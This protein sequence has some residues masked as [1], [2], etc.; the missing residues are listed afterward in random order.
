MRNQPILVGIRGENRNGERP[1]QS[2]LQSSHDDFGYRRK[3]SVPQE[4]S[5]L[6][7][8]QDPVEAHGPSN[9]RHLEEEEEEED[10]VKHTGFCCSGEA[11]VCLP[12]QQS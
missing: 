1:A 2:Y 5:L 4:L 3:V 8:G 6:T 10:K 12:Q 9:G 7:E 11:S